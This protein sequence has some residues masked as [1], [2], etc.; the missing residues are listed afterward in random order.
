MYIWLNYRVESLLNMMINKQKSFIEGSC[1]K[2]T[3]TIME[4]LRHKEKFV[5]LFPDINIALLWLFQFASNYTLQL[6][7]FLSSGAS[8]QL[9][10][11]P[12]G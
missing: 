3:F 4:N 2:K 11:N 9:S 7:T 8:L 6:V 5:K 10:H 12:C 1:T